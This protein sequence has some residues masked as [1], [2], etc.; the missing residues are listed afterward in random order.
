V[1]LF[2]YLPDDI[3][4]KVD[5]MSMAV[6]LESRVPFSTRRSSSSRSRCRTG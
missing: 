2:S 4:T 1:D 3:L 5:R 6:S